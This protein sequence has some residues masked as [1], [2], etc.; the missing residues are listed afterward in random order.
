MNEQTATDIAETIVPETAAVASTVQSFVP[1]AIGS[2][3]GALVVYGG[4]KLYTRRKNR[5]VVA[6]A[7]AA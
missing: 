1:F 2:V 6:A 4:Y 3:A 7:P 5:V